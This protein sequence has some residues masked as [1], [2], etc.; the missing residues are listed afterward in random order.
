VNR[1]ST[2]ATTGPA[3][4]MPPGGRP[5]PLW[6]GTGTRPAQR[7]HKDLLSTDQPGQ[8]WWEDADV[9]AVLLVEDDRDLAEMYRLTLE[10]E[11]IEVT[12][13]R[14]GEEALTLASTLSH[15]LV[16]M[17]VGLP[18]Q[19]GLEVIRLLRADP[20]TAGVLLAVLS[21]Y[22]DSS[23]IQHATDLGAL[24]YLIKADTTPKFLATSVRA[25]LA[26]RLQPG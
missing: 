26:E 1:I 22:S 18:K 20:A 14:D 12:I 21:N 16:L 6:A 25:W 19:S 11:G 5:W 7:V 3:T 8:A 23:M 9:A 24:A 4:S 13:A 10:L 15:D 2:R 17:D